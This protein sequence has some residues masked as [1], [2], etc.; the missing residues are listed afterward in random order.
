M[1]DVRTESAPGQVRLDR[2]RDPRKQP[3]HLY[4]SVGQ[5]V[6]LSAGGMRVLSRLELA[7]ALEVAVFRRHERPVIVRC[8]VVW[9]RRV[10]FD[11]YLA[12]MVFCDRSRAF[13]ARLHAYLHEFADG[14]RRR[15]AALAGS[16]PC[17]GG[18][19]AHE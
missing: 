10:G 16:G 8:A 13:Q 7:G 1:P 15:A 17:P 18:D 11:R 9:V 12:G 6:D 5:V 14:R 4:T 19:A 3:A 2:R